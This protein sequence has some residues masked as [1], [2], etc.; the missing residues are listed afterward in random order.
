[1]EN[2]EKFKFNNINERYGFMN[3]IYVFGTS[4]I[5]GMSL[6]YVLLKYM[7]NNMSNL[8]TFAC[9]FITVVSFIANI[10]IYKRDNADKNIKKYVAIEFIVLFIGIGLSLS[11]EFIR[12]CLLGVLALQIP[13]PDKENFKKVTIVY[14]IVL[15]G[16]TMFQFLKGYSTMDVDQLIRTLCSYMMVYILYKVEMVSKNFTDDALGFANVQSIKQKET[17]DGILTLSQTVREETE[18]GTSLI[19]ELVK[20][21]KTVAENM[22]GITE[23]ANTTSIN[24]EEQN[25]MTKSIQTAI[26]ETVSHS[27]QIVDIATESNNSIDENIKL[28]TYLTKQSAEVADLNRKVTKAM[29]KF[30]EKTIEVENIAGMILDISS[31]TNLLALNASI[32]SARAG[33]AGKGFAVVA[34]QIRQL[35]ERTKESTEE[36]T[37]ITT[38]LKKNAE[39]VVTSVEAS[40]DETESQ[41][42]KIVSAAS[43]FEKLNANMMQ[44]IEGINNIDHQISDLAVSNSKIVENIIELTSATQEVNISS[45]EVQ[46]VSEQN[47]IY[48]EDVKKAIR[49]VRETTEGMKKYL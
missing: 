30:N 32:E 5:W 39:N 6:L 48:A 7:N 16:V 27:R 28:M 34:E 17:M 19:D 45:K 44:L 42:K 31:Q 24:I 33:E 21:T 3:K 46:K 37:Y 22:A 49:L 14:S 47:L 13:Y 38:E 15:I 36:I 11:C 1:M 23:A 41:H 8:L 35:A 40:V 20:V 43:S 26:D 29:A 2:K 10:V 25:T 9:V 18:K 12:Y 4:I